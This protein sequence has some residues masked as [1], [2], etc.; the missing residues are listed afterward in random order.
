MLVPFVLLL[1]WTPWSGATDLYISSLFYKEGH[2]QENGF[3]A[4]L[5]NYG[6]VPAWIAVLGSLWI[7]LL[8]FWAAPL[9]QYRSAAL[10]LVLTLAIG[11][12]VIIHAGLKD[13][14]GRPRPKQVV[15]FGGQQAFRPY[16]ESN[17]F[18]QPEP[19]KS[20]PCGHCSMGFYFFSF[21]FLGAYLNN[22]KLF[23]SGLFLTVVLGTLLS[24]TRLM[25]GGHFFSDVVISGLIMFWVCGCLIGIKIRISRHNSSLYII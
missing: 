18:S 22:R 13:H 5:Y 1:I 24:I 10:Y 12:G 21:V 3:L 19:S 14:W 25:Q 11:S 4:F 23:Y 15:E 6:I 17:F 16:Y 9:K 8:S 2:F 7:F 20:F